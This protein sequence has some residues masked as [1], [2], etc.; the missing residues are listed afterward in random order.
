MANLNYTFHDETLSNGQNAVFVDLSGSIDPESFE[1]FQG[2]FNELLEKDAQ[3]IAINFENLKYINSTGMG[4]M[5]QITDNFKEKGG[6]IILMRI[7]SKVMLVMEMLGLQEFFQIVNSEDEAKAVFSGHE[8]KSA[9]VEAKLKDE[10]SD[11]GVA[12]KDIKT[13]KCANCGAELSV[14]GSGNYKCPRCK[15]VFSLDGAGKVTS[16][17]EKDSCAVEIAIPADEGF[18]NGINEIVSQAASVVGVNGDSLG[19]MVAAVGVACRYLIKY[20]LEEAKS[21]RLQLLVD[22]SGSGLSVYIYAAGKSLD[23]TGKNMAEV[24]EFSG[25]CEKVKR[26]EYSSPNGGN[27]FF[28]ENK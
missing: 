1:H 12:A 22:S 27:M 6:L 4:L 20:A 18:L 9:T 19:A 11:A 28:I 14:A 16:Y 3:N 23:L 17:P 5:V 21:E 10:S 7:P 26:L 24:A 15:A 2:M 13:A 25:I 8:V